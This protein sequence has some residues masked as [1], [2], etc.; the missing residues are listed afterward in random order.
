M[1]TKRQ[2]T[3]F[4]RQLIPNPGAVVCLH[5][6][7]API[8][9]IEG[10][11]SRMEYLAAIFESIRAAGEGATLMAPTFSTRIIPS[12]ED[13]YLDDTPSEMGVLTEYIRTLPDALR[14]LHPFVSFT[15][16]GHMA[17]TLTRRVSRIGYGPD[18]PLSRALELDAQVVVIGILPRRAMGIVHEVEHELGVPYRRHVNYRNRVFDG[19]KYAGND[20]VHHDIWPDCDATRDGNRKVL[21]EFVSQGYRL[22]SVESPNGL[23]LSSYRLVDAYQACRALLRR[24]IYGLLDRPPSRQPYRL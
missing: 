4:F 12:K 1:L 16:V 10:C 18:T 14:S 15:A 13:F 22:A 21:K 24:D 6:D 11:S 2:L 19:G 7:L 5:A 23:R 9:A 3:D 8:G 17:D 20:F